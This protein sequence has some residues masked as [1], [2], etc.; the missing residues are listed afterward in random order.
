MAS[1]AVVSPVN[2]V[3]EFFG[4]APSREDIV[5]FQLSPAARDRIQDLLTRNSAG[6]LTADEQRELDQV[7]LLDDILSLIRARAQDRP[8][9]GVGG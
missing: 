3:I 2:D 5:A 6:I 1:S 8:V 7:V 9:S 4:R